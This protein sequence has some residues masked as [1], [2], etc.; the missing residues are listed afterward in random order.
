MTGPT[1]RRRE[2]HLLETAARERDHAPGLVAYEDGAVVGW[3]S[4]GPREDY[5][6]LAFSKVLAPLDD[7]PVWS[8]VCFVVGRKSRGQGVAGEL[9]AAAIDYARDH[10]ATTLEAYP[11]E[12]T[13]GERVPSANAFQGTL[14]MF[15]RAG[16]KV[17]ARRRAKPPARCARSS[18]SSSDRPARRRTYDEW[19]RDARPA[20]RSS[21][22]TLMA[23][24]RPI[25]ARSS[26][27]DAS[28]QV[29]GECGSHR[30]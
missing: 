29:S 7:V 24:R 21:S 12:V 11:V 19:R 22:G 27:G 20:A 3:V 16:F 2:P 6:R 30:A 15:E 28:G 26:L 10:G 23:G 5:E 4:L 9:L 8:I 13:P 17:V 14:G 18:D 1:R 25:L